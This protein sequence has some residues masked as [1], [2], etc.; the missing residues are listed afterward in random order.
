MTRQALKH[1]L[2]VQ[3]AVIY[4]RY[5]VGGAFM[6]ASLIKIK[7]HRFTQMEGPVAGTTR[8]IFSI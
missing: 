7:G 3:L 5:L 8:G 1:P 2:L 6:F 4:T